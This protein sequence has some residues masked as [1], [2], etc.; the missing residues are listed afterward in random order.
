MDQLRLVWQAGETLL[1]SVPFEEDVE[2]TRYHVLLALQEMVTNV[3]RHAYLLD[4]LK[5]IEVQFTVTD[6]TFEV[7]L[8]DR[9]PEFDPVAQDTTAIEYAEGIPP[10][11]GGYGIY[12]ARMVMDEVAYVRRDG[13]N[14]LTMRKHARV[15]SHAR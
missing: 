15:S 10:A 12:I 4:E 14:V 1:E 3:L 7:E 9:G 8:R 2:S 11:A 13:W 6:A 5:P